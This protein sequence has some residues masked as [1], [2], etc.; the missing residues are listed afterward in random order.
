MNI[1]QTCGSSYDPRFVDTPCPECG[2]QYGHIPKPVPKPA[3]KI[4]SDKL[5]FIPKHYVGREWSK[6]LLLEEK[7]LDKNQNFLNKFANILDVIH[8]SF[9]KGK[10]PTRSAII[11][12]PP[13]YSKIT[14]AYS[15]MQLAEQK[16]LSVAPLLDTVE[17]KRFMLIAAE[18]PFHQIYKTIDYEEYLTADVCFITVTKTFKNQEAFRIILEI[19][20]SRSRKGLPTFIISRFT[21]EVLSKWDTNGHF[22]SLLED[23]MVEDP[24][25]NPIICQYLTK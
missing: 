9:S 10:L 18:R 11:V 15:C 8:T 25:K 21:V 20:D 14:W 13:R 5:A 1:C 2:K 17:L 12:A 3:Q 22:K 4:E 6:T 19:L 23:Y 7:K 16:G 24:Y